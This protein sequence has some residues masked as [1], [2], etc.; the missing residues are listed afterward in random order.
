MKTRTL[1]AAALAAFAML[2]SCQKEQFN[3]TNDITGVTE[4]TATIEQS[5]KT[6]IDAAG[7]ISWTAGDEIVV[8]DAAFTSAVYVAASSGA[9]TTFTLKD[10]ETAVGA[11]PYTATYGDVAH[12]VYDAAGANCPLAA[13]QTSTTKL[14]FSSPYAVVKFTAKSEKDEVVNSVDVTYGSNKSSLDCP[15]GVTLTASG[16]DFYVAVF[17]A[18]DAALSVTFYTVDRMVTKTRNGAV[19]LAAKDLLPLS[20]T[21]AAADWKVAS[22]PGEFSVSASKQVSFSRGNLRVS[23][24]QWGFFANQ[25]D[26][27]TQMDMFTWGYGDWS[28]DIAKPGYVTG[29]SKGET[30]AAAE[31]WAS[32][33]GDGTLWR[34]LSAKEWDYLVYERDGAANKCKNGVTVCGQKN[35]FVIAPDNFAGTINDSYDS[36]AWAAAE[37]QGLVCLPPAGLYQDGSRTRENAGYYWSSTAASDTTARYFNFESKEMPKS[38]S[39]MMADRSSRKKSLADRQNMALESA[40]GTSA[41]LGGQAQGVQAERG[42]F[43]EKEFKLGKPVETGRLFKT[44]NDASAKSRAVKPRSNAPKIHLNSYSSTYNYKVGPTE[45]V[46]TDLSTPTYNEFKI[47]ITQKAKNT[48]EYSKETLYDNTVE[49]IID[50]D[51]HSIVGTFT[52]DDY[53]ISPNSFLKSGSSTRNVSYWETS[54]ITIVSKG[55]NKYA[56]TD[57]LLQVENSGGTNLYKYNYC[58]DAADLNNQAAEKTAFEFT[59]GEE[60]TPPAPTADTVK[61]A[62]TSYQEQYYASY[63]DWQAIMMDADGNA[64]SLDI[65]AP[66]TGFESGKTYSTDNNDFDLAYTYAVVNGVKDYAVKASYTKTVSATGV[67]VVAEMTTAGNKV[68]QFSY[69]EKIIQ[70]TE[71]AKFAPFGKNTGTWTFAAVSSISGATCTSNIYVREDKDDSTRKQIKVE[72][73]GTQVLTTTGVD[74]IIDWDA[75]TNACT[76]AEQSTGSYQSKYAEYMMISD[77]NTYTGTTTYPSSYDPATGKFTLSV[78]YY[79]SLGS[80]GY[81]T[82]T[83]QMK[84]SEIVPLQYD[85]TTDYSASFGND[86]ARIVIDGTTASVSATDANLKTISMEVYVPSGSTQIP[87]GDYT[88]SDSKEVGTVLASEGVSGGYVTASFAGNRNAQGQITVPLWFLVEGNVNVAYNGYIM[89]MTVAGKNSNG[90]NIDVTITKDY[91]PITQRDTVDIVSNTMYYNEFI[92]SNKAVQYYAGEDAVGYQTFLVTSKNATSVEGTFDIYLGYSFANTTSG[93][94]IS[95]TEGQFTVASEEKGVRLTGWGI[96]DDEKYYRLNW[97]KQTVF[98]PKDIVAVNDAE[99]FVYEGYVAYYGLMNFYG[100]NDKYNFDLFAATDAISGDF[101]EVFD[102]NNS[103]I[104]TPEGEITILSAS[105]FK[106]EADGKKLTLTASLIGSDLIQ[107]DITASGYYGC[108]PGDAKDAYAGGFALDDVTLA[109]STYTQVMI[110]GANETGDV[111]ALFLTGKLNESGNLPAGTYSDIMASAGFDTSYNPDPSFVGNDNSVWFIQSGTLVVAEDGSMTFTG[112]NSYD[113]TVTITITASK[114]SA[115]HRKTGLS[116]RLVTDVKN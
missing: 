97:F 65:F 1:F 78:I 29:H 99:F 89:T 9:S 49:L 30:L 28:T 50:P 69:T 90:K 74:I 113:K 70:W 79:I 64:Y 51:Q 42:A 39:K 67:K 8:T 11:G 101:K 20:L 47:A 24:G 16:K 48:T 91:T 5:A 54:T 56:I 76:I 19:T 110:D 37:E 112:L 23:N 73:W 52:T 109:Q 87:A 81:G 62:A 106:V 27:S 108:I 104:Q 34:T 46:V 77:L 25:Y 92:S 6:A 60:P 32:V 84:T 72:G 66:A 57:G 31:D 40:A 53:S 58:Y 111:F 59:F 41:I 61:V 10:G 116:V 12:Q 102:L 80:F 88:V 55:D 33:V 3:S 45:V 105:A 93:S 63:G 22:L 115:I 83:L 17:P 86:D 94:Q 98:D 107:Y 96:G 95:F 38:V 15:D 2:V 13:A 82:E 35:C 36:G 100:G 103:V 68:Y 26:H 44:N 71:W 21:L 4:F 85:A 18:S 7:K 114:Q 14:S 75:T 43:Q